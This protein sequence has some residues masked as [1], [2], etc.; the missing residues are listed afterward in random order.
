MVGF[1]DRLRAEE[2]G[3]GDQSARRQQTS[4]GAG[5]E[6]APFHRPVRES[7]RTPRAIVARRPAHMVH[8]DVK[9]VGR[10]LA[11][12]GWRVHGKGS[13]LAKAV[14]AATAAGARA[15]YVYLHSAVD[16]Y[17]RLAYT[18]PLD[19]EKAITAIGF[20]HRA[21]VWFAAHGI[22]RI[23]RIV[24]DNGACYRANDFADVLHGARHQ[25]ITPYTP[26]QREGGALQPDPGRGVPPRADL[27]LRGRT[28]R[29]VA[30]LE[31]PLQLPSAAFCRRS[32]ATRITTSHRRHQRHGRIQ[33]FD[34][35]NLFKSGA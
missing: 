26:P 15:G 9:K 11:G 30:G 7:N 17:S 34:G 19:N 24:T 31:H 35:T 2:P 32:P 33:T 1:T 8:V 29:G 10:I 4:G 20:M 23:E 18:E 25:R 22:D 16:G 12:G 13:V 27:D 3:R 28:R 6:P 21:R 5:P 14:A